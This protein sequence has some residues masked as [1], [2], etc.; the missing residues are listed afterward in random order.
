[1]WHVATA[2]NNNK[3]GSAHDKNNLLWWS[4]SRRGQSIVVLSRVPV[5]CTLGTWLLARL[6]WDCPHTTALYNVQGNRA[7]NANSWEKYVL[8]YSMPVIFTFQW[9]TH[10]NH[11]LRAK[12]GHDSIKSKEQGVLGN[13]NNLDKCNVHIYIYY[14]LHSWWRKYIYI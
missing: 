14:D 10:G 4:E 1:M 2:C 3:I 11:V 5:D 13:Q 8:V 9:Q 7:G 12:T 6:P